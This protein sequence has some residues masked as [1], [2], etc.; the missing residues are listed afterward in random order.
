ME[1]AP[2]EGELSSGCWGPRL[3]SC[4]FLFLLL[5]FL[6]HPPLLPPTSH[7]SNGSQPSS[8]QSYYHPRRE[9]GC[10]SEPMLGGGWPA[11]G[12]SIVLN[13]TGSCNYKLIQLPE[14]SPIFFFTVVR[15][16]EGGRGPA[17]GP[18]PAVGRGRSWHIAAVSCL[19]TG[20]PFDAA[21]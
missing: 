9:V 5:S 1:Q 4:G 19:V 14:H 6:C 18:Q 21:C 17:P 7:Y 3:L 2:R 15:R 13:V 20:M 10:N 8:P 12:S 11:L 16:R